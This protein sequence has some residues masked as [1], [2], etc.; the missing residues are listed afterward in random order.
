MAQ[1]SD[2]ERLAGA[3]RAR[4]V[5]RVLHWPSWL[6]PAREERTKDRLR[7][8]A[9]V[10]DVCSGTLRESPV[11]FMALS[12]DDY[13][14]VLPKLAGA[15][16]AAP[17]SMDASSAT[18]QLDDAFVD[19]RDI[20]GLIDLLSGS[21]SARHFNHMKRTRQNVIKRSRDIQKIKAEHDFYHLLPAAMQRWFVMPFDLQV[22]EHSASYT[23][24]RLLVLDM[25][26]Q[27][28]NGSIS[29]ADFVRFLEDMLRFFDERDR[30]SCS[31][32]R[33]Q[34]SFDS[35]YIEKPRQRLRDLEASPSKSYLDAMVRHGT[36][37]RSVDAMV[38][39]YL[40]LVSD[41]RSN[42]PDYE[43][44]GHGDPCFSNILYEKRIRLTKLIDPKGATDLDALYT[45]PFYDYAKLS[46]SVL[47]GYDFITNGL[48]EVTI[49]DG[50]RLR[51]TTPEPD[52]ESFSRAFLAALEHRQ[53][54]CR[55]IRV[56][57]ASLFLSMLP[58][59]VDKPRNL[60]AFTA[61]AAHILDEVSAQ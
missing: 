8:M 43:S 47:G 61:I 34:R 22:D 39:A 54:D 6:A 44:I 10:E 19:I 56:Y 12:P 49:D 21:F 60:L 1:P 35:L 51:L 37:Y 24:E 31:R 50:L 3:I 16:L 42:L 57:E 17:Q 46:H 58:L 7:R 52:F 18:I 4:D 33:A 14:A 5:T 48:F 36:G 53:V 25:G 20:V 29:A 41:Y 15:T 45:D 2:V 9:L 30:R 27:W 28:I 55:R 11:S 38:S 32:V 26:Q 40:D 59:H 13:L 23:M